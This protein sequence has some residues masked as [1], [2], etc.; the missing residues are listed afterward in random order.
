MKSTSIVFSEPYVKNHYLLKLRKERKLVAY[1]YLNGL[2]PLTKV[3]NQYPFFIYERYGIE[4]DLAKRFIPYFDY[5]DIHKDYDDEHIEKMK[6]IKKA[7]V[8]EKIIQPLQITPSTQIIQLDHSFVP[9]F[10]DVDQSMVSM[11]SQESAIDFYHAPDASEQVYAVFEAIVEKLE[12][13]IN[14]NHIKVVHANKDD[15]YQLSKL[16][17]DAGVTYNFHQPLSIRQY[18]IYK[19]I[20]STFIEE[21]LDP[22]KSL[23]ISLKDRHPRVSEKLITFF[24]QIDDGYGQKYP[25]I[26]LKEMNKLTIA[27]PRLKDAIEFIDIQEVGDVNHHYLLMNYIDERFPVMTI[28]NDYLLNKQK[29][30]IDYPTSEVINQYRLNH[31]AHLLDAL[32]HLRLFRPVKLIDETR[33][34]QLP[35]K[36]SFNHHDYAYKTQ[37]VS[38]LPNHDFLRYGILRELAE[39][40]HVIETDYPRLKSHYQGLNKS[41]THQFSGID[42]KDLNTLL[43]RKYSLTGSKIEK[44]KLCPF[45]YFMAHLMM[46]DDFKDN[47]Y[48]YFGNQ[49]HHALEKLMVDPNYDYVSAINKVDDFPED[50]AYKKSVFNDILIDNLHMIKDLIFEFHKE[51]A[52]KKILTEYAFSKKLSPDDRFL[53]TGIIDKIMIDETT[54]HF[55]IVDYKYSKKVFSLDAFKKG[56]KLQLPFYLLM[57]GENHKL[58]PTGLFYR[59]TG[60]EKSKAYETP[61]FRL[62]G[63][64]LDDLD[65]MKRLDPDGKHIQALR[66]TRNGMFNYRKKISKDDFDFMRSQ[67][68]AMIYQAADRIEHGDF[69]I[70]PILTEQINKQ[71]I[72][73]QYCS[74]AHVCYSKNTHLEEVEDD[75]V[76]SESR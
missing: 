50:I 9:P 42:P 28:D 22:V 17:D 16:M 62:N 3:N 47:H 5:I 74:F 2:M 45:Q 20:Q 72:S 56:R 58:Q 12:K 23:I 13:G 34:S 32:V 48:I 21:G 26:L 37:S 19:S 63:V 8:E 14:I 39:N 61:D 53:L 1:K 71:S 7:L 36:R 49:I 33:I 75:E 68:K 59:Q 55:M 30:M 54:G 25:Q 27:S 57:F 66:Y 44:L 60:M 4:N 52:Y 10:L 73:C 35:L 51:T 67:M 41:F 69:K 24:N 65:L 18:P 46:M 64:F 38:Y 15:R 29:E 11:V 31:V 6:D 76:Y 40:Y 43:N 70:E